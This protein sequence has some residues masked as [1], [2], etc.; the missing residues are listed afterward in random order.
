MSLLAVEDLE[1]S[2][3]SRQ[4]ATRVIRGVSF[5]IDRGETVAIVGESS[6]GKSVTAASIVRLL[7]SNGAITGG[8]VLLDGT[9]VCGMSS[10]A[11]RRV[12]GSRIAMVFQDS[13]TAL[14]PVISIGR[15]MIE[16]LTAHGRLRGEPARDRALQLLHEVS[17]PEPGHRMRQYPHQLSGGLRQRIAVAMALGPDPDLLIADEPT[18]ALD[19]TVQAQLLDLLRRER[20]KRGMALILI[21]HDLGIVAGMADRVCVM[22]AGRIVEAGPV[23]VVFS[24]PR[25]PYTQGLLRSIPRIDSTISGRLPSIAG[26]PP[27]LS[28]LGPGCPFAPRCQ[29]VVDHCREAEPPLLPDRFDRSAACWLG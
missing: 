14:N 21:T 15:Q 6:S 16:G 4:G 13:M 25:H 12:R 19:V 1:T 29:H 10:R 17:V 11:L 7:P 8:R 23:Q 20:D 24:S 5:S 2:F 9:D 3:V 28:S 18:T 22:Y 27:P 26:T